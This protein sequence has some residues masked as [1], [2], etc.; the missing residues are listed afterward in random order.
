MI[1][2]FDDETEARTDLQRIVDFEPEC[3]EDVALF[4]SDDNGKVIE[5]PI[6]AVPATSAELAQ[7]WVPRGREVVRRAIQTSMSSAR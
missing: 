2:S 7:E 3:A 5:G 4:A 6:H 1:D